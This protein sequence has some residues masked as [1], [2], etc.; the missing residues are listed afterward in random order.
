LGRLAAGKNILLE[1]GEAVQPA[2]LD[3]S[4][5]PA[6]FPPVELM[7]IDGVSSQNQGMDNS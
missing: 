7:V 1:T 4:K 2:N 6:M 5:L 3:L